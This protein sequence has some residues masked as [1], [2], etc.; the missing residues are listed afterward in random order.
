MSADCADS[1]LESNF[2]IINSVRLLAA[3]GFYGFHDIRLSI[4]AQLGEP[5]K[6]DGA[7]AATLDEGLN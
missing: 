5:S 2:T 3:S 6:V 4:E 7:A 1:L